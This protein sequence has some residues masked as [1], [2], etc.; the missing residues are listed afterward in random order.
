M[1][2]R[3]AQRVLPLIMV[4]RADKAAANIGQPPGEDVCAAGAAFI[5]LV[6]PVPEDG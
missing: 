4:L 1:T 5:F 3:A 2:A 6:P